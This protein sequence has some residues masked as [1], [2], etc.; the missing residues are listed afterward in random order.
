VNHPSVLFWNNGNEGGFNFD[1]DKE[2]AKW[3]PQGRRVLH[4][5]SAFGDINT[6]HYRPYDEVVK[7]CADKMLYMPTEFLH[8][9]Y[10]GGAG[11]GL[12]DY[13]NVIR[14]SPVGAGGFLWAFV[15]EGVVRTDLKGKVDPHG[16]RG[17][18]G[19]V[20]PYREK[21][22]SFFTIRD[23]WSPVQFSLRTLPAG[24]DGR[25]PVENHYDFT[26]LDRVR[27]TWELLRFP[28]PL[29]ATGRTV[30]ARGTQLGPPLP[31]QAKGELALDLPAGWPD[32]D[33]LRL[34]ATDADGREIG[35]WTWPLKAAGDWTAR[36]KKSKA[37]KVALRQQEKNV[38]VTVDL[39]DTVLTF[40]KQ[41]GCLTG[42]V[43][44][45]RIWAWTPNPSLVLGGTK[46][47]EVEE[48]G[49]TLNRTQ[50]VDL[51]GISKLQTFQVKR[52]GA[53]VVIESTFA[54]PLS[55]LAWT[56]DPGGWIR[57]DYAYQAHGEF[58]IAGIDFAYPQDR[59][60]AVRWLGHG[61]YRAWQNRLRGP[62]LDVWTLPAAK[63]V[64]GEG[65]NYPEFQGYR[66]GWR[67]AVLVTQDGP[68][69][70]INGMNTGYLG[71][72]R[73][74][75][76]K[77]PV[78]TKLYVP[79]TGLSILDVIP[80]IGT[81]FSPAEELGPQ[82]QKAKLSGTQTGRIYLQF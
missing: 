82:S 64:P 9:L 22:G 72:Y 34:V 50:A 36:L 43:K 16:N 73:P 31:P 56:V 40:S 12:D 39:N 27:F 15:D 69:S 11:A 28:G 7:S 3:D 42:V 10:D 57:L 47:V 66:A 61:P 25:L 58:T 19:I 6:A 18:D 1:L 71:I 32:A 51:A 70:V 60:K 37:G 77:D 14:R 78:N 63:V 59:V 21:E 76:A 48:D 80:A 2:Y 67:W 49:K 23:V 68:L 13:W 54:G 29:D 65:W 30:L 46:T 24:F 52:D 53:A 35:V 44:S 55:K 4:P 79:E 17:P 20:G 74:I 8:G 75:D 5:W 38:D 26:A 41:S 81:K 62:T 33:A 45:G